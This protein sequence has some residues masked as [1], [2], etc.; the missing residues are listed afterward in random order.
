M[1]IIL[2][3][4]PGAGKGT[5]AETLVAERGMVQLSTG[6][7]L[8][9]AIAEQTELG[10][11]AQSI[12]DAGELVPD[13]VMIAMIGEAMDEETV[14]KGVILDGFPRTIAQAEALDQMLA[15]RGLSL[16]HVIEIQVDE[17][18]L[19]DRIATR[20]EQTGNSRSDDNAETLK[21]RLAVYHGN[22]APVLPYYEQKQ[23]LARVDGMQDIASVS[24]QIKEVLDS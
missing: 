11:Q 23:K 9:Q 19:F 16:D 18:A 2:F 6:N 8:R 4:P 10:L 12:I 20:A 24:R 5:Q 7:M 14:A 3:G 1:N 21:Q 17:T 13:D 15:G 22:T